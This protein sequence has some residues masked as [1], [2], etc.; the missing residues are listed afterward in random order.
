MRSHST[1]KISIFPALFLALCLAVPARAGR[2]WRHSNTDGTWTL[3]NYL[4]YGRYASVGEDEYGSQAFCA[5]CQSQK[6]FQVYVTNYTTEAQCYEIE[7][8]PPENYPAASVGVNIYFYDGAASKWADLLAYG[9]KGKARVYLKNS[10]FP[11]YM[12]QIDFN[13]PHA[14][15]YLSRRDLTE[16]QCTSGQTTL[17]WVKIIDGVMTKK[18]VAR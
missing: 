9:F 15:Y 11:M 16:T 7:I 14:G 1:M 4:N 12:A 2:E 8:A 3:Y 10:Q 17:N 13:Q 5:G 6:N 18:L